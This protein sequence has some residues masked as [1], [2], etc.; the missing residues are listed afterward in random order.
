MEHFDVLIIGAGLS[1]IGAA[2]HLKTECAGKSFAILEGRAAM[3]GTWDLFRYPGIR[4]DS[5]MFT[6]G[7]RF[8]PWTDPKAI[9]DG[10]AILEVHPRNGGV[11]LIVDKEIRYSHRVVKAA[12]STDDALWTVEAKVGDEPVYFTC[13]FLYFCTGYYDYENGYTPDFPGMDKFQ[14]KIVHPQKWTEDIDYTGKKVIVIG[15]GA[16]AVT[17]VPALATKAAHVTMLQRSPTYV[18]SRPAED[19]IA[20][21]LR[22]MLPPNAAY[23]VSRWKN[24]L[25]G[26]FFYNFARSRPESMKR[27]VA[28]GVKKQIGEDL[29]EK[30]FAPT[31]NPWDQR[32]CLVPDADL[33]RSIKDGKATVVTDTIETFTPNG[34]QLKSGEHLDAD[35]IVTATGLV[36]KILAGMTLEVDGETIDLSKTMTYKGMMYSDIPNAAS[37]LGYTNASWTLKC[38][39]TAQY[40]CRMLNYMDENG[41]VICTPRLNDPTVEKIPVVD[42]NSGYIQR[43]IQTLPSQGSKHPWRLHQNYIKDLRMLRH[44]NL[45]DGTMEFKPKPKN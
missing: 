18:V 2:A 9:A 26:M 28:K 13:N 5:D 31:Y 24:V 36:M 4:S 30:H 19:K 27:L 29:A 15:S 7:Y 21:A 42:F 14:G 22:K 41:Y 8:R 37:A 17:L 12:W 11:N 32:L 38:D 10:P 34:I 6:L 3:G 20:N 45:E 16:T 35:I 40:V 33:F 25:L 44:G 39:L 23:A 43:A 1:G